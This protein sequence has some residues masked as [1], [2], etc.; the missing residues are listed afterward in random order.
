MNCSEFTPWTSGGQAHTENNFTSDQQSV[1][2]KQQRGAGGEGRRQR[3]MADFRAKLCTIKAQNPVGL[4]KVSGDAGKL[5]SL[6]YRLA[7]TGVKNGPYYLAADLSIPILVELTGWSRSKVIRRLDELRKHD[8]VHTEEMPRG[9][10]F[11]P[12]DWDGRFRKTP[13]GVTSPS[14]KSDTPQCHPRHRQSA[15]S[16]YKASGAQARGVLDPEELRESVNVERFF[17]RREE[18]QSSLDAMTSAE[19]LAQAALEAAYVEE[20]EAAMEASAES[21][22]V[23]ALCDP[24]QEARGPA[25]PELDSPVDPQVVAKMF[26]EMTEGVVHSVGASSAP[27]P[28]PRRPAPP[29]PPAQRAAPAKP[30]EADTSGRPAHR[31][32]LIYF[33]EDIEQTEG[34]KLCTEAAKWVARTHNDPGSIGAH[35]LIFKAFKDRKITQAAFLKI[36]DSSKD[37]NDKIHP[38]S[39][40]QKMR[41][42]IPGLFKPKW[43]QG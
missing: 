38:P 33:L 15:N 23:E 22:A 39:Y 9:L 35:V 19:D 31:C 41:D 25:A 8:L 30:G 4:D 28:A 2:G 34:Y 11:Y 14:V 42:K 27:R 1:D 40:T 13:E 20:I 36:W 17:S 29:P 3:R 32:K 26:R 6:I 7:F 16:H 12:V 43:G 37:A 5:F 24:A 18:T 21:A 10:T